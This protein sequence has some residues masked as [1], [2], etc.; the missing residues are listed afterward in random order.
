MK[1]NFSI[2]KYHKPI[3]ISKYLM[4]KGDETKPPNRQ[5]MT[6][7]YTVTENIKKNIPYKQIKHFNDSTKEEEWFHI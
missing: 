7:I 3:F 1:S 4:V 5:L 2:K 6:N